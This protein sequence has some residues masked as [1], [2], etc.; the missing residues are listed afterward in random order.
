MINE[1]ILKKL[2]QLQKKET[3][4]SLYDM[5][6]QH[7]K[8]LYKICI[9]CKID[10]CSQCE[11]D[12]INHY[13]I[14]Q[15]EIVPDI[16]EIKKLQFGIQNYI[17]DFNELIKNIKIWVNEINGK[18]LELENNMK[19][20]IIMN[21][22]DFVK[23]Y[24]NINRSLYSTIKFRKLY[25]LII[26]PEN[27]DKNIKILSFLNEDNF[28]SKQNNNQDYNNNYLN[29]EYNYYLAIKYL[30]KDINIVK[31]NIIKKSKKII[32]YLFK[33]INDNPNNRN[34]N[35]TLETSKSNK[36]YLYKQNNNKNQLTPINSKIINMLKA[37][38]KQDISRF[39]IE[40]KC[41]QT[42]DNV[43]S[44]NTLNKSNIGKDNENSYS[45]ISNGSTKDV[46]Y[47]KK[48]IIIL[49]IY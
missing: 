28:I 25:S 23:N 33:N 11:K 9:T 26:E 42:Y 10:I 3:L 49:K 30:L 40:N 8:P 32:E 17:N 43:S 5:C 31:D 39:N 7:Q 36:S 20:N 27:K 24:Y 45:F 6:Q 18:I 1:K 13:M 37:R 2:S 48:K 29:N 12:H 21:S 34:S 15:E 38:N 4:K 19:N 14:K 46:I 47:L 35:K 41:N 22:V 44:I 16:E